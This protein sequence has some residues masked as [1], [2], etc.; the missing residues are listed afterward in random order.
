MSAT[1][2]PRALAVIADSGETGEPIF[3][4]PC[5]VGSGEVA[6][7]IANAIRGAEVTHSGMT[8]GDEKRG[9]VS[10]Y[11]RGWGDCLKAIKDSATPSDECSHGV[12]FFYE[13]PDCRARAKA[14]TAEMLA[15]SNGGAK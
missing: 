5:S 15:L 3:R 6:K 2:T 1:L 7:T 13:C 14:D 9:A 11:A 10:E 8:Y 4:T 12:K